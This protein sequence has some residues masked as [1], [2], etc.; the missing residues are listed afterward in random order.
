MESIEVIVETLRQQGMDE[1]SLH[2]AALELLT[3]GK[4][5]STVSYVRRRAIWRY[6]DQQ[7]WNR[8]HRPIQDDPIPMISSA[9][10]HS[11][12][13]DRW[14]LLADVVATMSEKQQWLFQWLIASREDRRLLEEASPYPSQGA[15]YT[16][17]TRLR[18]LLSAR[19]LERD[20]ESVES[21]QDREPE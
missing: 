10:E 20:E 7:L 12:N 2:T 1:D 8:Q 4:T 19:L 21:P 16:A 3:K 18:A 15:L 11:G 14:Q 17:A 5:T 9:P 13:D 6:R